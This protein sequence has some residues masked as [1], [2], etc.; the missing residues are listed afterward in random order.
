MTSP[1]LVPGA[2]G[3]ESANAMDGAT[4]PPQLGAPREVCRDFL[5]VGR[6]ES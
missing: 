3:G 1:I 6:L 2:H 5:K 4:S